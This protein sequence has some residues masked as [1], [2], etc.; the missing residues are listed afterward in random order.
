MTEVETA[1][2]FSISYRDGVKGPKLRKSEFAT[3]AEAADY[4][5]KAGIPLSHLSVTEWDN[6][7]T[8]SYG[9]PEYV[10]S[11]SLQEAH[12]GNYTSLLF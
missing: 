1:P 8:D 12:E 3:I 9:V 11:C 10:G 2:A 4:A 5:T 7:N 6:D